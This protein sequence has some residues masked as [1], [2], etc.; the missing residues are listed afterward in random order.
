[1]NRTSLSLISILLISVLCVSAEA[2][3]QGRGRGSGEKSSSSTTVAVSVIFTDAHRTSFRDYVVTNKLTAQALPP[4]QAMNVARGKALPP[5]IAK[6]A[7]P[8][9]L[10]ALAPRV[11]NDVSFAIVG[12]VIV[13]LRGGIV[14]DTMVGLFK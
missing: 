10:L 12:N 5:G 11:G 4:G 1:M 13:A 2:S 9:G 7:L 8:A 14:I 6:K 3:S